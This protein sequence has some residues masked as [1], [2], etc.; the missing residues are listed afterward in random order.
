[1]EFNVQHLMEPDANTGSVLVDALAA[2]GFTKLR[3]IRCNTC[4]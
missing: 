2:M 4:D 3:L 1:M